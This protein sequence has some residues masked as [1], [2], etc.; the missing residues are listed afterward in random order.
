[1]TSKVT[2]PIIPNDYSHYRRLSS[3]IQEIRLLRIAPGSDADTIVAAL[4][5]TRLSDCPRFHA[6]S[7]CWGRLEDTR[8]INLLFRDSSDMHP[9]DDEVKSL[10]NTRSLVLGGFHITSNLYAALTS[11]RRSQF[12]GFMWIDMLC[13]NQGDVQERSEQVAIM[14]DIYT[15]AEQVTVWLGNNNIEKEA[16][17]ADE[18]AELSVFMKVLED[19]GFGGGRPLW[20]MV[21]DFMEEIKVLD[22]AAAGPLDAIKLFRRRNTPGTSSFWSQLRGSLSAIR[23]LLQQPQEDHRPEYCMQTS[24][25]EE[26]EGVERHIAV[27]TQYFLAWLHSIYFPSDDEGLMIYLSR[28]ILD[29][30]SEVWAY[31]EYAMTCTMIHEPTISLS[32]ISTKSSR[33]LNSMINPWFTRVWV[34]QE[35]ASNM[36]VQ[37]RICENETDFYFVFCLFSLERDR[38]IT[39]VAHRPENQQ[40]VIEGLDSV[41]YPP[42]GWLQINKG[43]IDPT[44]G[45]PLSE[46]LTFLGHF[47]ATD[48]RD[49][50]FAT[51]HLS[52][53]VSIHSFQP[54]YTMNIGEVFSH[55][56]RHVISATESAN[57]LL[58]SGERNSADRFPSWVPDYREKL[59]C[60]TLGK[61]QAALQTQAVLVHSRPQLL[62]LRGFHVARVCFTF[63]PESVETPLAHPL[64]ALWAYTESY[65]FQLF[66]GK[67]SRQLY[68]ED[69][70]WDSH[71]PFSVFAA[72]IYQMEPDTS[73]DWMSSMW[74]NIDPSL[75]YLKYHWQLQQE[76]RHLIARRTQEVHWSVVSQASMR[77]GM[78]LK[79]RH[80]FFSENGG[81]GV[82]PKTTQGGD[83]IVTPFGSDYPLVLRP[84]S[85]PS[86]YREMAIQG[87]TY[88]LIGYCYLHGEM[89]GETMAHHT[90]ND[91]LHAHPFDPD[92]LNKFYSSYTRGGYGTRIFDIE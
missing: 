17:L 46:I 57:I 18:N 3:A 37:V 29:R 15:K 10:E 5:R 73:L 87:L 66:G 23:C 45:L 30:R 77:L 58:Y 11:F 86:S 74:A 71:V 85:P 65:Y 39:T 16:W 43:F 53:D 35:V 88:E 81:L 78:I 12:E 7:Y 59:E 76:M 54:D 62:R 55:F 47:D 80:L 83:F 64:P 2:P 26:E 52:T 91:V 31:A 79:D 82:C 75:E 21:K 63:D 33:R 27:P 20:V 42:S 4:Y 40:Q 14:K 61:Y 38:V 9:V 6:L 70:T 69:Q 50:I 72:A 90:W 36:N 22:I 67:V 34:L 8:S 48:A 32:K 89:N 56:T 28:I 84:R 25:E 19:N 92:P 41:E 1:M 44:N 68:L 49:K 60:P 24:N 13:I 51:Y